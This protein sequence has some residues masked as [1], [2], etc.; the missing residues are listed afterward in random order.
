MTIRTRQ[1]SATSAARDET[2]AIQHALAQ[3][4]RPMDMTRSVRKTQIVTLQLR[5]SMWPYALTHQLTDQ[6]SRMKV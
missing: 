4:R 3:P 1:E 6:G 2:Q 5:G